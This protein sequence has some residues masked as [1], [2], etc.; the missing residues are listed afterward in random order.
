[1]LAY[2]EPAKGKPEESLKAIKE[3]LMPVAC[4]RYRPVDLS[5]RAN[6]ISI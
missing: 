2:Y 1:M 5:M 4:A 6:F 3:G